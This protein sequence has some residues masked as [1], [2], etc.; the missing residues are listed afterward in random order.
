V[1]VSCR[2]PQQNHTIYF[3]PIISISAWSF[4]SVSK[5]ATSFAGSVSDALSNRLATP[6]AS[7]KGSPVLTAKD[8]T[9]PHVR[10]AANGQPLFVPLAAIHHTVNIL[11]QDFSGLNYHRLIAGLQLLI[12]DQCVFDGGGCSD[13][14]RP[15]RESSASR[16][17][18]AWQRCSAPSVSGS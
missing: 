7:K 14:F 18:Q 6:A 8:R 15:R 1:N 10:E 12:D 13:L 11:R 3:V 5:K 16:Q 9:D 2:A 17:A 4:V